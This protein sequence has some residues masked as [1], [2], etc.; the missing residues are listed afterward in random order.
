MYIPQLH[1]ALQHYYQR[2]LRC[3]CV[4]VWVHKYNE[5]GGGWDEAIVYMRNKTNLY[6]R[7]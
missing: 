1:K 4:T 6:E 5:V 3:V 2:V 7:V